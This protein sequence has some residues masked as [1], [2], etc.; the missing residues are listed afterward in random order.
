MVGVALMSKMGRLF[1]LVVIL[2]FVLGLGSSDSSCLFNTIISRKLR[3]WHYY[4]VGFIIRHVQIGTCYFIFFGPLRSETNRVLLFHT[5]DLL[6]EL[7]L[8]LEHFL[9]HFWT[10]S[11]TLSPGLIH[12]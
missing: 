5:R 1:F 7:V 8:F 2:G 12:F 9:D 6:P 11:G 10:I 3:C 4:K